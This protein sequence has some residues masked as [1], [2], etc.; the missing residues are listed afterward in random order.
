MCMRVL[1]CGVGSICRRHIA[2]LLKLE[3]EVSV[4]RVRNELL[5]EIARNFRAGMHYPARWGRARIM[6][7]YN[8]KEETHSEIETGKEIGN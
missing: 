5:D 8:E 4:W 6:A 3:A 7:K 2:N 1:A